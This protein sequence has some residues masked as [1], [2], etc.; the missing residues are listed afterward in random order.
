MLFEFVLSPTQRLEL[1]IPRFFTLAQVKEEIASHAQLKFH[2]TLDSQRGF[3]LKLPGAPF[4]TQSNMVLADLPYVINCQHRARTPIF[5]V[6]DKKSDITRDY[7]N[8][9]VTIGAIIGH[10][11][12]WT[13]KDEEITEYRQSMAKQR[14]DN[15]VESQKAGNDG[16]SIK[17]TR[18]VS[19]FVPMSSL[20]SAKPTTS[21]LKGYEGP[22]SA[23]GAEGEAAKKGRSVAA[24]VSTGP[25]FTPATA[26][27]TLDARRGSTVPNAK[28][29]V[30]L[31]HQNGTFSTIAVSLETDTADTVI[32]RCFNSITRSNPEWGRGRKGDDYVLK[33]IGLATFIEGPM[34]FS[35]FKT[36]ADN[37]LQRKE[38][39]LDLVERGVME[40][41]E[42]KIGHFYQPSMTLEER[43]W[44]YT[45]VTAVYDHSKITIDRVKESSDTDI[46]REM[47]VLSVWDIH[48]PLSFKILGI[49]NI[50][51]PPNV[52]QQ[53]AELRIISGLYEG[54]R[55]MGKCFISDWIPV[56]PPS[57]A[58]SGTGGSSNSVN[59]FA[60]ASG[61]GASGN[62]AAATSFSS[63]VS[64]SSSAATVIFPVRNADF[65]LP[66]GVSSNMSSGGN[67]YGGSNGTSFSSSNNN[68]SSSRIDF[69][70]VNS[71]VPL[72]SDMPRA[73][74]LC[75]SV[76]I[77]ST[78][79]SSSDYGQPIAW[80]NRPI[81][82][83][84]HELLSGNVSVSMW[85]ATKELFVGCSM[86]PLDFASYSS[87]SSSDSSLPPPL[88][89]RG[90]SRPNY[91]SSSQ[92][93]PNLYLQFPTFQLPVV[94]PTVITQTE[95]KRDHQSTSYVV[96]TVKPSSSN[97][98]TNS[99]NS[100]KIST[101]TNSNSSKFGNNA[102]STSTTSTT[103]TPIT[104]TKP[105]SPRN[106][107]RANASATT[108]TTTS[109]RTKTYKHA[110][111]SAT[112]MSNRESTTLKKIVSGYPIDPLSERERHLLWRTRH[113][114]KTA[115]PKAFSKFLQSIPLNYHARLEAYQIMK[116]WNM[117]DLETS[118]F[119]ELLDAKFADPNIRSFAVDQLDSLSDDAI[120]DYL[121]QLIQALRYEPYL[122][123]ALS[124]FLLRRAV[125]SP[126]QL[127][128]FFFWYLKSEL[129]NAETFERNGLL[130]EAFLRSCSPSQRAQF[131]LQTQLVQSL[132]D[133]SQKIVKCEKDKVS[134]LKSEIHLLNQ[135][136]FNNWTLSPPNAIPA[137]GSGLLGTSGSGVGPLN[138]GNLS[139]IR[140]SVS[141]AS[142][143]AT[144]SSNHLLS[145]NG[146]SQGKTRRTVSRQNSSEDKR[147]TLPY[148]PSTAA[149]LPATTS[150]L[151]PGR[152]F[153]EYGVTEGDSR[154]TFSFTTPPYSQ[155]GSGATTPSGYMSP[156]APSSPR[157]DRGL[158]SN[159]AEQDSISGLGPASSLSNP[160]F[161]LGLSPNNGSNA[162]L[163][164]GAS[165]NGGNPTNFL[166]G[167]AGPSSHTSQ[168]ISI[169][170]PL[171][172]LVEVS[173]LYVEKCKVMKSKK[174][175]LWLC[176]Q[177]AD[178]KS[179]PYLSIFKAGD[180][181]RQDMLVL[182][183]FRVMERVWRSNGLYL[184]MAIYSV[185]ATG[186]Q[187]GFVEIVTKSRT[188]SELQGLSTFKDEVLF[189]FLLQH[190][191]AGP[192]GE[193][194]DDKGVERSMDRQQGGSGALGGGGGGIPSSPPVELPITLAVGR[195]IRSCAAYCV[196][197]YVLGIGDRH[198]GNVMMRE[199][200]TLFHIDFGHVLGN[201]KEK[202]G[203]RRE[204]VPFVFT[205]EMVY[206]MGDKSDGF[207]HQ[208]TDMCATAYNLLRQHASLF[209]NL[210][211]MMMSSG[212][213]E[214][215]TV[216]DL[217]YLKD[218]LDLDLSPSQAG[219]KFSQML[220]ASSKALSTR[221]NWFFHNLAQRL[222]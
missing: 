207:Y 28:Y 96:T 84:D 125:Q 166:G 92:G 54:T 3:D 1:F 180:D 111:P 217:Y 123:C 136:L 200:G 106:T 18:S 134:L 220:D 189:N 204:R 143:S 195:F 8:E 188:I 155:P 85:R 108:S 69:G 149:S 144:T 164:G 22:N 93:L 109:P 79:S 182:Q 146:A 185:L 36:V 9:N 198:N 160:S 27:S 168:P 16:R 66:Q 15:Y 151:S 154:G 31:R 178:P 56:P 38:T 94:F 63:P 145:P 90:A 174:E 128:H 34:L 77:R 4:L 196:A 131:A 214:L 101:S 122:D 177:N 190:N 135:T 139:H 113:L 167:A 184:D 35:Q 142:L 162:S 129:H 127:G 156:I 116:S 141:H 70:G 104:S 152:D 57:A 115:Q 71:Q 53:N 67:F 89:P 37:I 119:L 121:L 219:Y 81:F 83:F 68:S 209:M 192:N 218:T 59:N 130:L 148:S 82:D 50:Y 107:S 206:V 172:P 78:S 44:E 199:D 29:L 20:P 110:F 163:G 45:E 211:A 23:I 161:P 100:T 153:Q 186:D 62:A 132:L 46:L 169:K 150:L 39:Q 21:V 25:G 99:A 158:G 208:F 213:P 30:K 157:G 52:S 76:W 181:L 176:F 42:D 179:G 193:K 97:I 133:I 202:L 216:Q 6:L 17:K 55:L 40:E 147:E 26:T 165:Q 74:Q 112:S 205:P 47:Q 212:M 170:L 48:Q 13:L 32:Q 173:G 51:I 197:T 183:L 41:E 64:S 14:Y 215:Q 19:Q 80:A 33:P 187:C 159:G 61:T 103:S 124:R 10:S 7:K 137:A 11:L 43:L 5:L 91:A 75:F 65:R 2:L 12:G 72:L 140:Q 194:K 98:S 120:G 88:N 105:S 117:E 203:I 221:V 171:N 87:S 126:S 175:P 49:D 24:S 58:T 191:P 60:T 114:L 201:F 222:K 138:L 95:A 210:F 86:D 118:D 73:S 102:S